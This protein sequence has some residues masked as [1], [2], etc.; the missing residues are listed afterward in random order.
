GR[1]PANL[2]LSQFAHRA[3]PGEYGGGW[4]LEELHAGLRSRS[5]R[6]DRPGSV[7]AQPQLEEFK[8]TR[9]MVVDDDRLICEMTRDALEEER[10]EVGTANSGSAALELLR[11]HPPF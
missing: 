8:G 7:E 2:P 3:G 11:E 4:A 5:A 1:K 10:F 6:A 9:V